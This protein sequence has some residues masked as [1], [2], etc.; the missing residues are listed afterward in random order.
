MSQYQLYRNLDHFIKLMTS[1]VQTISIFPVLPNEKPSQ[2]IDN[3]SLS[4]APYS[5]PGLGNRTILPQAHSNEMFDLLGF[6]NISSSRGGFN[7]DGMQ[8]LEDNMGELELV[9][10][11]RYMP[12]ISN[13][14]DNVVLEDI[15]TKISGTYNEDYN[16][17][18][19]DGI[20]R[21]K[22]LQ[23]RFSHLQGLKI[24]YR[25]LETLSMQPQ[26]YVIRE[27]TLESMKKLQDEITQIE[28]GDKLR[29]YDSKVK[30]ILSEYR[31]FNGQVKTVLFEIDE[32][33]HYEELND[34]LRYR[35]SL[36]EQYLDIAC[37]Y[38]QI[39]VIRLN[40]RPSDICTGCG[41]SLAKVATTDE[42]TIR[43][44]NPECQTEHNMIIL[45]K[46]AKDGSRINTNSNTDDE[47]I[48]NF[49]RA[50][51]R[52]QGLQPD[53]PDESIYEDLDN[54]FSRCGRPLGAEI[55]VLPLNN[56]GRRGDTNHKMLWDALSQIGHSEHYEDANLIGHLY[57]GWDL[58][59]VMHLKEPIIDKYHKTQKVFYQIPA[60]ERGRNSS[61]GTQYRLW[62]HLQLEGHECYMDEFKIAENP[63]SIRTH[64]RLW[65]LMCEGA[66]DPD[67]QYIP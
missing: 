25:S 37:D 4:L 59:K 35:I 34:D 17:V 50:F 47:S 39:D 27:K 63:E 9:D 31:K 20:I 30:N 19:V 11:R 54:Y 12:R 45:A 23:E 7:N 56:R 16:I 66:N 21:K 48:D 53:R 49:L 55:R 13:S 42:G 64:N 52:Y 38:I 26:T 51:T 58:P 29:L 28:S 61:L 41:M 33:E 65:R 62:R 15:P 2:K 3:L 5:M 18:Y 44:P 40:N 14:E 1:P 24:R 43:C 46:L 67:I 32:E 10:A 57:W 6:G 22:L 36:I 8:L 60:E